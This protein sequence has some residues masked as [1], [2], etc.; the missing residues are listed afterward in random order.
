MKREIKDTK[1]SA[2]SNHDGMCPSCLVMK[3]K[4][5][6]PDVTNKLSK[7]MLSFHEA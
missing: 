4:K 3:E 6:P 1:K 5:S 2:C 7:D